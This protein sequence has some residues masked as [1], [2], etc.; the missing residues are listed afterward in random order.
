MYKRVI[1]MKIFDNQRDAIDKIFNLFYNERKQDVLLLAQMQQGKTGTYLGFVQ[2]YLSHVHGEALIVLSE[3]NNDL[4]KQIKNDAKQLLSENILKRTKVIHRPQLK[5][6]EVGTNVAIIIIDESHLAASI[7]QKHGQTLEKILYR[8]G[9]P[10]IQL[11]LVS[12]TPIR[13]IALQYF[14]DNRVILEETENYYGISKMF[15]ANRIMQSSPVFDK[16]RI[17]NVLDF[18]IERLSKENKYGII[19]VHKEKEAEKLKQVVSKLYPHIYCDIRTR[20]KKNLEFNF[21]ENIPHRSTLVIITGSMRV[22]KQLKTENIT[23]VWDTSDSN[24][25]TAVQGLLGRCCG[26]DKKNHNVTIFCDVEQARNYAKIVE[27][28]FTYIENGKTS[29]IAV[30]SDFEE[31][32]PIV[33]LNLGP[34]LKKLNINSDLL[35]KNNKKLK[36]AKSKIKEYLTDKY[37]IEGLRN[38]REYNQSDKRIEQ[39][40]FYAKNK[41]AYLHG[42]ERNETKGATLDPDLGR[43][44]IVERCKNPIYTTKLNN[45][46][47]TFSD[48]RGSVK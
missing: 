46:K 7:D 31:A 2:K 21:F 43:I 32:K 13:E 12:A 14:N 36:F 15:K 16:K 26:Y 6:D 22:G 8:K 9:V 40:R 27:S 48:N 17:N 30:S 41:M 4:L 44:Y 39:M 18:Q 5:N 29:T 10:P 25:D 47:H 11:L 3:S 34:I 33:T 28:N 23:F 45:K 24:T 42:L 37:R 35:N 20:N 19:R 38:F 1:K